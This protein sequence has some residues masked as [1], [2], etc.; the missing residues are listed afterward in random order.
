[1]HYH[2]EEVSMTTTTRGNVSTVWITATLYAVIL[3]TAATASATPPEEATNQKLDAS[4]CHFFM[5]P[6]HT[7]AEFL[8]LLNNGTY[9]QINREHMFV[10]IMDQG[11]WAQDSSGVIELR[12]SKHRR[13]VRSG[14]LSVPVWSDDTGEHLDNVRTA[15]QD[16][17]CDSE[18]D[19]LTPQEVLKI[20]QYPAMASPDFMLEG[21]QVDY[22]YK[23]MISRRQLE[24]LL[25]A[26]DQYEK[27]DDT[28]VFRVTPLEYRGVVFLE[29]STDSIMG[30]EMDRQE[31][32]A[33]LDSARE[34]GQSFPSFMSS[35]IDRETFLREAGI[36]QPFTHYPEMNEAGIN[37]GLDVESLT[38]RCV[39][40]GASPSR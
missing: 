11:Q 7:N 25:A 40:T 29:W 34:E 9:L 19:E 10:A 5:A 17:L 28:N 30:L 8:A 12:S 31:A 26:L 22:R 18:K 13:E 23:D 32:I 36:T 16:F 1:M 3:A 14:P 4:A 27:A 24:D 15:L 2:A 20:Y 37:S 38:S 6:S 33:M 35:N 39:K 21:I